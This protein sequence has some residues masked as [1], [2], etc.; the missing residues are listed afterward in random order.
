[1]PMVDG[2]PPEV[3]VDA[4]GA[5]CGSFLYA[6]SLPPWR[7]AALH[8]PHLCNPTERVPRLPLDRHPSQAFHLLATPRRR[9]AMNAFWLNNRLVFKNPTSR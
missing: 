5:I 8:G 6:M 2:Y 9:S 1:M 3:D 7:G 4:P